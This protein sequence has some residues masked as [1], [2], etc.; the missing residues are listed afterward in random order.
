MPRWPTAIERWARPDVIVTVEC[1][2]TPVRSWSWK[3]SDSREVEAVDE[4]ALT[5]GLAQV[6][7]P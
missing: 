7:P 1:H 3:R 4:T 6:N 5:E 2:P